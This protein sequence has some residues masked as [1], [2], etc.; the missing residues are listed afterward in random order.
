[1]EGSIEG[2]LGRE[3]FGRHLKQGKRDAVWAGVKDTQWREQIV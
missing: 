1:M 3:S 2:R